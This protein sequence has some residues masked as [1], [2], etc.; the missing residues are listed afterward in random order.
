MIIRFDERYS[1]PVFRFETLV[2]K[3]HI[4]HIGNLNTFFQNYGHSYRISNTE[5]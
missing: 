5:Y 4:L 2:I 3:F 1:I